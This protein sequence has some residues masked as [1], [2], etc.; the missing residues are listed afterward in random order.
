MIESP[1]SLNRVGWT[2]ILLP[3]WELGGNQ[4]FDVDPQCS[5]EKDHF[6]VRYSAGSP[7]DLRNRLPADFKTKEMTTSR[8]VLLRE[9]QFGA[10][11]LN[12]GTD[13][14]SDKGFGHV[15]LASH[16]L[17]PLMES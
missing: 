6:E 3:F 15:T 7:L 2:E 5:R 13:G 4:L 11:L 1:M 8:Q 16:V 12:L 10:L 14:I 17:A 9:L